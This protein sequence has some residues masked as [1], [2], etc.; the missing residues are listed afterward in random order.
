MNGEAESTFVL[1]GKLGELKELVGILKR[2]G[3]E[4]DIVR[5]ED[6]NPGG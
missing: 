2:D 1:K 3:I 4:S 6:C 5:P